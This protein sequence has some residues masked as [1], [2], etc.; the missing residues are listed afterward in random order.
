MSTTSIPLSNVVHIEED[1]KNEEIRLIVAAPS[2]KPTKV[3][4]VKMM[5]VY[6]RFECADH[7]QICLHELNGAV[8]QAKDQTWSKTS[9]LLI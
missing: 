9:E 4:S 5:R 6:I 8:Q 2:S 3:G 7:Y 1:G